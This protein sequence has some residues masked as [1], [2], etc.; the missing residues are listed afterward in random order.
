MWK[1]YD[2]VFPLRR[3]NFSLNTALSYLGWKKI[4]KRFF[5]EKHV[6][7]EELNLISTMIDSELKINAILNVMK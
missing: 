4:L 2:Y 1:P 6:R 5:F 3:L 7:L